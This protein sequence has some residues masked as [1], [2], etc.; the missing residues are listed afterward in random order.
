MKN[1]I[2]IINI[3]DSSISIEFMLQ[4]LLDALR[5]M[6]DT[7]QVTDQVKK[8]MTYLRKKYYHQ[9]YRY[10]LYSHVLESP[11]TRCFQE[12]DRCQ[13]FCPLEEIATT[14]VNQIILFKR[15]KVLLTLDIILVSLIWNK[16]YLLGLQRSIQQ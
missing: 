10:R 11:S 2:S 8:L 1:K 5:E 15:F 7:D 12:Y 3:E 4:A 16:R 13:H 6:S 14:N 9:P